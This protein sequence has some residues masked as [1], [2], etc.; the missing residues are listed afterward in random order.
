MLIVDFETRSRVNLLTAGTYNYACSPTTAVLCAAFTQL[1]TDEE[2]LWY[3]ADGDLPNELKKA[4]EE[5]DYMLAHNATFDRLIWE[6]VATYDH[7]FP[8]VTL[9]RWYCTSAQ[10][11]VNN[12]PASLD[13]ATRALNASHKKNHAGNALIRYLS[14]PNKEGKFNEDPQKLIEMGEY[15]LDDV[16]ATKALVKATRLMSITEQRD[17]VNNEIIN[18]RGVLIDV[19]LAEAAQEY[20]AVE[21]D[22]IG[23]LLSDI[24]DGQV[25]TAS[26][27]QRHPAWVA[28]QID[29]DSPLHKIMTKYV[30]DVP[31]LSLD[32]AAREEALQAYELGTFSMPE[33][34]IEFIT[35]L[36]EASQSSVT[37]FKNMALRADK[38][39]S[40]VNGAFVYA[41]ASQSL[42][43][44]SRGLQLHNMPSRGLYKTM[45]ETWATYDAML[46]GKAIE[47]PTMQTLKKMLR[48]ALMPRK[49]CSFVIGDWTGIESGVLPWLSYSDG[50]DKKL[51]L[52]EEIQAAKTAGKTIEDLYER[53]ARL[54][55][56]AGERGLGKTC[57]LALGYEGGVG[58]FLVFAKS[59][60]IVLPEQQIK[61]VIKTWRS[62]NAW[63]VEFWR[64][65]ENAA[66]KAIQQPNTTQ[67]AGRIR[68]LFAP[69]L[70][71]GSLLCILPDDTLLT[72]PKA[73]LH[74]ERNKLVITA[75][76]ASVKMKVDAK[77]WPR[78]A[79]YGGRLAGI[80]TQGTAAALLRDLI[81]RTKDIVGHVHDEVVLEVPSELAEEVRTQLE[82]EM[83]TVPEWAL[84]LP[85]HAKPEIA[86]RYKK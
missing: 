45:D 82:K 13:D 24:T 69:K 10:A 5:T 56:H 47:A 8:P 78:E 30:N 15:C 59:N 72:F 31:K 84:D 11:R 66:I 17:Y 48:H 67:K 23:K 50:G 80:A 12:I 22:E 32:K 3:P 65:L 34:V 85:L 58:A 14:I 41:G 42:R 44:A 86:E 2:W 61:Q 64:D 6:C 74:R 63:V 43:F 27:Y 7:D 60:G 51:D 38:V 71:E 21:K 49:G 1:E 54:I 39:S 52:I 75:L 35:L 79:L 9:N 16:R 46:E 55:G 40:R 77:E 37:K 33:Q 25:T 29:D 36:D 20:A 28:T 68:Y 62:V 73:K 76:K 18:E 83:C 53:T 70:M 57:E 19:E 26:Q 4:I 81:N